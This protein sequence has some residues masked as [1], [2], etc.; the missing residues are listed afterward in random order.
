[1]PLANALLLL[2]GSM[3]G[4]P[5]LVDISKIYLPEHRAL[6]LHILEPVEGDSLTP[7][8]REAYEDTLSYIGLIHKGVVEN[9]ESP[10]SIIR[11]IVAT[12]ARA[13]P[14]FSELVLAYQPRAIVVLAHLFAI[15]GLAG[16]RIPWLEGIAQCQ[17]PKL[18][19]WLSEP[20][21]D[22]IEWPLKMMTRWETGDGLKRG[23]SP[24]GMS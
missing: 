7:E 13:P 24:A 20:W 11:R 10:L 22:M 5:D 16:E 17:L 8:D 4:E 9:S 18:C 21:R 19:A 14:R 23:F 6:F 1:M 2:A 3:Y 12:A 15:V